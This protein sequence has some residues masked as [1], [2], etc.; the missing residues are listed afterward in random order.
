MGWIKDNW[1]WLIPMI[2][3]SIIA[4]V[5]MIVFIPKYEGPSDECYF[6]NEPMNLHDEYI[7]QVKEVNEY[8]QIEILINEGDTEK[9]TQYSNNSHF[10]GVKVEIKRVNTSNPEEN[11]NFDINDFKLKDH[12]GFKLGNVFFTNQSGLALSEK[13]FSTINSV[14][15]YSYIG[16]SVLPGEEKT[17]EIYF[18]IPKDISVFENITII[19]IDFFATKIGSD[20]VLAERS[21]K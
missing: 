19:E 13:D 16:Q 17:F 5:L 21:E 1:K 2:I 14:E 12:T 11:H 10:L 20:V 15:D 9:I 7:I 6:I 3:V 4:I 8:D 18:E